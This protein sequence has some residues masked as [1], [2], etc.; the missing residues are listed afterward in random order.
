MKFVVNV[1]VTATAG[2]LVGPARDV[3]RD[4]RFVLCLETPLEDAHVRVDGERL[5]GVLHGDRLLGAEQLL[6]NVRM[7]LDLHAPPV[8]IVH[9]KTNPLSVISFIRVHC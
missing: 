9:L 5:G 2:V 6:V 3:E 7:R 4:E 8:L 1:D